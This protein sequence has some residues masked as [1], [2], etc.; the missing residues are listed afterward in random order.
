MTRTKLLKTIQ[1]LKDDYE[2]LS[3][4][5]RLT[6][7]AWDDARVAAGLSSLAAARRRAPKT[8]DCR[9]YHVMCKPHKRCLY[10]ALDTGWDMYAVIEA[11]QPKKNSPRFLRATVEEAKRNCFTDHGDYIVKVRVIRKQKVHP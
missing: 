8:A 2:R 5:L 1:K 6:T 10:P 9:K 7:Q 3:S 11:S 4:E